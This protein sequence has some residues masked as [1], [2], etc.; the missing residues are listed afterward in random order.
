[1]DDI[2]LLR[3]LDGRIALVTGAGAGIGR[4]I[5]RR[6]AAEGAVVVVNDLSAAACDA[7]VAELGGAALATPGDVSDARATEAVVARVASQRGAPD[8]LFNN[9]GGLRDAPPHPLTHE[10]WGGG[11]PGVPSAG[12]PPG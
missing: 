11:P 1:M 6:L 5:A 12:G 7:V 2:D 9:A 8:I 3:R 10:D 4:A